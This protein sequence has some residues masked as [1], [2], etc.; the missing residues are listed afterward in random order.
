MNS[1]IGHFYVTHFKNRSATLGDWLTDRVKGGPFVS[2]LRD[3]G[4]FEKKIR[5]HDTTT[6]EK[7]SCVHTSREKPDHAHRSPF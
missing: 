1:V 3:L 6:S 5:A 7:I 4:D 2:L